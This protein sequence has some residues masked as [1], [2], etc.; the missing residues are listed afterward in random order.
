[1]AFL[2]YYTRENGNSFRLNLFRDIVQNM[3]LADAVDVVMG[4][5]PKRPH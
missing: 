5:V 4:A 2:F 1:M 3:T